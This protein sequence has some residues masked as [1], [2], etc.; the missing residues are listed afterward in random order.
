MKVIGITGSIASGKNLLA[1]ILAKNGGAIFDA[2]QVT[3]DLLESDVDTINQIKAIFPASYQDNKINRQALSSQIFKSDN[4]DQSLKKLEAIIHPKVRERYDKFTQEIKSGINSGITFSNNV[5]T[6]SGINSGITFLAAKS[7]ITGDTIKANKKSD[8]TIDT[9]FIILNIPLLLESSAYKYDKLIAITASEPVKRERFI[10]RALDKNSSADTKDLETKFTSIIQKQISDD[11]RIAAADFVI[12]NNG[13]KEQLEK[14]AQEIL[15]KIQ[16]S[17]NSPSSPPANSP[18][19][20]KN[21][22]SMNTPK[23]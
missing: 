22:F 1:E 17:W 7:S 3:H 19:M 8:T 4:I 10:K 2:D 9:T 6:E 16:N 13:S 18:A 20:P 14:S 23:D 11:Q 12:D 5:E 15:N 21:K